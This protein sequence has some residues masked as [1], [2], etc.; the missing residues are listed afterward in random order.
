[1]TCTRTLSYTYP[2]HIKM[3]C[4]FHV[5]LINV[6]NVFMQPHI[7]GQYV[8]EDNVTFSLDQREEKD[9]GPSCF[10]QHSVNLCPLTTFPFFNFSV[11]YEVAP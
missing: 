7:E 9:R 11:L 3:S 2:Q 1:M 8:V 4:A 5:L 10:L 6:Y